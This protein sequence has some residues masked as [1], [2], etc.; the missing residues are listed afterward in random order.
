MVPIKNGSVTSP[1]LSLPKYYQ[2]R[3]QTTPQKATNYQTTPWTPK[4]ATNYQITDG[5]ISSVSV[6]LS[7]SPYLPLSISPP[8]RYLDLTLTLSRTLILHH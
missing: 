8:P 5:K 7:S 6:P 4:K 2:L 1:Y 3:Y